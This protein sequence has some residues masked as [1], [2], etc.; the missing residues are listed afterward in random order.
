[1]TNLKIEYD[2]QR[3]IDQCTAKITLDP[4][5]I[6]RDATLSVVSEVDVKDSRAVNDSKVLF[7]KSFRTTSA[8]MEVELPARFAKAYSYSGEQIDIATKVKLVVND[9]LIFDSK[10]E[11]VLPQQALDKPAVTKTSKELADPKDAFSM[12]RS[13]GAIP[14]AAKIKAAVLLA[15]GL[16]LIGGMLIGGFVLQWKFPSSGD[17][18]NE[19]GPLGVA[20]TGSL[21]T[22]TGVWYLLRK[23][24]RSYM[25]FEQHPNLRIDKDRFYTI[26]DLVRGKARVP[27]KNARLRVVAY[28]MEK[29][30]Y[31][32]GSGSNVRIVS[33]SNPVNGMMLYDETIDHIP[34]RTQIAH[35]FSGSIAF[36]DM[37]RQLY[38]PLTVSKTHGLQTHWEVQ[39]ILDD[40]I[41]QEVIGD[42]YS[43]TYEDFLEG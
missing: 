27:L 15:A 10:A 1:M 5:S 23:Q 9:A 35:S 39:L 11:E 31:K 4:K 6:D 34:A 33:V 22:G 16:V 17:D 14:Y 24:L 3:D 32:R 42:R 12:A 8:N 29:G 40:L 2:P 37:F 20:L 19:G 36:D 28:N 18:D 26:D 41:D 43:L 38:P 7:S 25:T 13:F 30:Q 21:L